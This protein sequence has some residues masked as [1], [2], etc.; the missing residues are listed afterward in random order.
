[1]VRCIPPPIWRHP[2]FLYP[3]IKLSAPISDFVAMDTMEKGKKTET[4]NLPIF[5]TERAIALSRY[6]NIIV[7]DDEKRDGQMHPATNL[8]SPATFISTYLAKTDKIKRYIICFGGSE[9]LSKFR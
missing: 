8:E 3:P 4:R 1:M 9:I 2:P 6:L 5:G 7:V